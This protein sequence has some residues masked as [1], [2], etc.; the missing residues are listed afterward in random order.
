MRRN[1]GSDFRHVWSA[2]QTWLAGGWRRGEPGGD[3]HGR[4]GNFERHGEGPDGMMSPDGD[5][6]G[7]HRMT[8][9]AAG[10]MAAGTG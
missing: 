6:G 1:A 4:G 5:E 9:A 8:R 3:D 7:S 2:A 10:R